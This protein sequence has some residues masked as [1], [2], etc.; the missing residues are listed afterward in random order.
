MPI[1]QKWKDQFSISGLIFG[2]LAPDYDILFRLT[3]VRFHIFQYD[4]KTI[5]FLIFP[6]TLISAFAFHLFCRNIIIDNLPVVYKTQY[7][8][9][10]SFNF[11][12]YFK[13]HFMQISISIFFAIILHLI[14]DFLCHFLDATHVKILALVI[15]K[16]DVIG[17]IAYIF[18]IYGLPILFSTLGVYLIFKY[19]YQKQFSF[20]NLAL[21]KK[22]LAFWITM[23]VFTILF[24][25][26]KFMI[27]EVDKDFFIDFIIISLTSSFLVAIYATC[28]F[29]FFI[30]KYKI[31]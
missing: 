11:T 28:I 26:A 18:A 22:Q 7:K 13:K 1:Q 16:N 27:T 9:Y 6:L 3:K 8:K 5:L 20:S 29:Y 21:T 12:D 23:F 4:L 31:A 2:S 30:Q 14:L 25:I 10:V 15:T 24:S 19:E 17:N